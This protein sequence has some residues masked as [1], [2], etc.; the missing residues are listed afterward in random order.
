METDNNRELTAEDMAKRRAE[1]RE[2]FAVE[3]NQDAPDNS[4]DYIG[5]NN[6]EQADPTIPLP[7]GLH[8]RVVKQIVTA[9][10][11]AIITIVLCIFYMTPQCLI[12]FAVSGALVYLAIS[13]KIDYRSGKIK[14]HCFICASVNSMPLRKTTRIVFRTQEEIP[15]YFEFIVPGKKNVEFIPNHVY[16]VY[17]RE[18]QPKELLGYTSL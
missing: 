12:G 7:T 3:G 17:F 9:I 11:V 8:T 10:V 4:V 2:R 1:L 16:L 6:H 13:V 15:L 14:E 18:D 5:G